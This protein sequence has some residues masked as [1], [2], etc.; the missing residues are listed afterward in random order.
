MIKGYH[1]D[2]VIFSASDFMEEL[3]NNHQKIR[4]S[5]AGTSHQNGAAG[6]ANKPVVTMARTM[7][8]PAELRCP[9]YT[10]STIF[11]Q[12]QWIMLYE[13]TIGYL[14]YS[15]DYPLLKYGQGQV[16]N[17]CQKPLATVVFGVVQHM[18]YNRSCRSLE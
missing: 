16:W 14:I 3:L 10:L 18:F 6:R 12:C 4:F 1:T 8:M 5:G 2:N 11:D 13:S 7:L 17:Q 9:K 15:L